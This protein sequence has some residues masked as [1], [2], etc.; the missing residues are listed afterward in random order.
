M[1]YDLH[2]LGLIGNMPCYLCGKIGTTTCKC[3]STYCVLFCCED[4]S[5]D[6]IK[7]Y[8]RQKL[9]EYI[10]RSSELKPKPRVTKLNWS[11]FGF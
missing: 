1:K 9:E 8:K 6:E 5:E 7:E 3:M 11:K 4:H 2:K 10:R